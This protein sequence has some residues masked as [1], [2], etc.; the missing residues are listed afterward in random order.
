MKRLFI[1][2]AALVFAAGLLSAQNSSTQV[3]E[4]KYYKVYSEISQTNAQQMAERFDAY[5][6]LYNTYFHFDADS[7]SVKLKVKLL[8]SK[9]SYER[10]LAR[11][12]PNVKNSF[13]YLQ[14]KNEEK[15]ELVGYYEDNDTFESSLAHHGFIQY[16][17]SFVHNPPIWMQKGFAIF[18]EKSAYDESQKKVV[19]RENLSWLETLKDYISKS[20]FANNMTELFT[21]AD[22]LVLDISQ[23]E[24]KVDVFYAE[25]WGLVS[26]LLNSEFKSYN[27]ILWDAIGALDKTA[28]K[29]ANEQS[30]QAKAFNWVNPNL[31][32]ADFLNYAQEVK[33]FP[34][35]VQLGMDEYANGEF[36][37][38]QTAFTKALTIDDT[39][40]I[41]LYY[42]GLINYAN[43]DYAMAEYY[44]HSSIQLGGNPGL[45]YYALGVNSYADNRYDDAIFY[46]EQSSDLDPEGYGVKSGQ[47]ILRIEEE[48]EAADAFN[49]IE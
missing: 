5:F 26:F 2:T 6:D 29:S 14:Y 25:S 31:F 16:L 40:Y 20:D 42:L 34:E 18:F 35:L 8:A 33:S 43:E 19:Y 45:A 30:V 39:H 3:Y 24:A 47:L 28:V 46:L 21:L 1:I 4:S 22:F 13:V 36:D 49:G 48:I 23:A 7:L 32:Q 15:S 37:L 17:K 41:P 44:Y 10:Y 11:T 38:A 9:E 12:V 27:R